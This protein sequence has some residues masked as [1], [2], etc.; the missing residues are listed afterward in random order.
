MIFAMFALGAVFLDA[1][2]LPALFG[3]SSSGLAALFPITFIFFF[4]ISRKTILMVLA[5][6]LAIE[7]IFGYAFGV[8]S[9][10][11]LIIV[12]LILLISKFFSMPILKTTGSQVQLLSFAAICQFVN[13][14]LSFIFLAISG[15]LM[16]DAGLL[17]LSVNY[18][19]PILI[20]SSTIIVFIIFN[21]MK[22]A[23]FH[24]SV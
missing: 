5:Y 23:N 24:E 22:R 4:G 2:F 16:R 19:N 20:M 9:L 7:S 1:V 12:Y 15:Y 6:C 14:F 17:S 13:Y 11:F 10:S 8:Y 18:L 21:L 3:Y